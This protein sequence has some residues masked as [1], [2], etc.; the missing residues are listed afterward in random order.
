MQCRKG[1]CD[2]RS[3]KYIVRTEKCDVRREKYTVR[4]IF[5]TWNRI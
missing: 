2:V 1:K 5:I 4:L 3:K